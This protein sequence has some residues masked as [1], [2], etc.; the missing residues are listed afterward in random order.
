[1][2]FGATSV[3]RRV[4]LG[5]HEAMREAAECRRTV[6]L[7]NVFRAWWVALE[8]CSS[9]VW[10]EEYW[11]RQRFSP[12]RVIALDTGRAVYARRVERKSGENLYR[13][14]SKIRRGLGP[15]RSIVPVRHHIGA[16]T[17]PP[18]RR[19]SCG[20]HDCA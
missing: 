9:T 11:V 17:L 7:D 13:T 10:V 18:N 3:C 1:M 16:R 20:T 12:A 6:P 5:Q 4:E 14:T 2:L 8:K 19:A 15:R